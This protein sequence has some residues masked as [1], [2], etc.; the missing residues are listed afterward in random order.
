VVDTTQRLPKHGLS[1]QSPRLIEGFAQQAAHDV[2]Y[3][4]AAQRESME[5]VFQGLEF[6]FCMCIKPNINAAAGGL[7]FEVYFE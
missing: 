2:F 4:S 7:S 5:F 3:A 6:V 1:I